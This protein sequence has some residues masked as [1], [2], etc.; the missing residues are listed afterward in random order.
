MTNRRVTSAKR[1]GFAAAT[2]ADRPLV[3]LLIAEA[4]RRGDTLATMAAALGVTYEHVAQWRRNEANVAKASRGVLEAAAEYLGISTVMVLCLIGTIGLPDLVA[5]GRVSRDAFVS[6]EL[7]RIRADPYFAGFFPD[8]LLVAHPELQQF[9]VMLY[10]EVSNLGARD[11]NY[12]WMRA[13]HLAALG[14]AE[15]E[16]QLASIRGGA[17]TV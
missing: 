8:S 14:H 12:Q 7:G 9:V 17:S 1:R 11:Q 10:R 15:A 3:R 4:T 13:I 16:A 6:Q 2:P 5:P